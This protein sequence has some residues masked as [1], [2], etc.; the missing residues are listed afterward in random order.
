MGKAKPKF[1]VVLGHESSGTRLVAETLAK[2]TGFDYDDGEDELDEKGELA[3]TF[4]T[5]PVQAWWDD[6][7]KI[8][9][10]HSRIS[11]RSLPHGGKDSAPIRKALGEHV[12]TRVF[13]APVP[14]IRALL[15]AGYDVYAVLTVR[16][17]TIAV[18]SKRREHTAGSHDVAEEE[19]EEATRIL[20]EVLETH[21]RCFVF[22]YESLMALG[23]PYLQSLYRFLGVESDYMPELRDG[24][25]KYVKPWIV[26]ADSPGAE[27]SVGIVTRKD[28]QKWGGD[29]RALKSARD[30]LDAMGLDVRM[31]PEPSHLLDCDFIF[32][33]NTCD[34]QRSN[35]RLLKEAGKPFGL[36]G[37]HEDFLAYYPKSMGFTEYISLCLQKLDEDG[38]PLRI[39]D[40]WENPEV[41]NYYNHGLPKNI[42]YNV[43][44]MREAVFC[45]AASDI[46]ARTMKRD[47]PSSRVETV[48][49]DVGLCSNIEAVYD[50]F[51]ELTGLSSG[52]YILQVGRLETRKNQLATILATKD[53]DA[54]LVLIG[55]TGYQDW[56][57]LLV[58][59]AGAKYR[60]APTIYISQ[61]HPTQHI[62]GNMRILQMPG[63]E[64]LPEH[65]VVSAYQHCGLHVH[66]AFWEA[67]GYTYLE[68]ARIGVPTVA[69]AWG[70][71][72]DYCRFGNNDP[73]MKDR[74]TYVCPY[75]LP[76]MEQAIRQQFGRKVDRDYRHPI[77]ERASADVGKEILAY[78]VKYV[79]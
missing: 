15:D 30:G 70:T 23:A 14:F 68:A 75:N 76:E 73:F 60:K 53:F 67:P 16:D 43:P 3:R 50:D 28:E 46:E 63:G 41:F 56:Y 77:F 9:C 40:L 65:C 1:I 4:L 66:P 24:N 42:F 54:P 19:M 18:N 17:K 39:E 38:I 55:T 22:S 64:R 33:N 44:V 49:W 69:S 8:V 61:Q 20:T 78:L 51:L 10:D 6:P 26:N 37:F 12:Q 58:V 59:N 62:G 34:D 25:I 48:L 32:L 45:L 36:I 72:Q 11:R 79:I 52:E 31:A 57:E 71:L 5:A 21:P 27:F 13:V 74:F 29:L 47:C 35:M 2:A 7:S